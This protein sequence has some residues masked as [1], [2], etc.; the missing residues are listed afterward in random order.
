M[1]QISS[2]SNGEA[3]STVRTKLN[4]VITEINLLDPTD[5]IDYS[6]TSTIVGWSSFTTKSIIYRII[7]K[8]VFVN[9]SITGNSNSTVATFTIPAINSSV[10]SCQNLNVQITDNGAI[11]LNPGRVL[12]NLSS[13]IVS[14]QKDRLGSS[15]TASGVKTTIG[16]FFYYTD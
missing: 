1:A 13:N 3:M 9:F 5:W 15:F 10:F 4:N 8:Q 2:I 12:S 7:G 14:C 6:A 16:Q 11:S